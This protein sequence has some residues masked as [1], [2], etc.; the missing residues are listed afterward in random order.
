MNTKFFLF[1][2]PG[3]WAK[4]EL[5]F[6]HRNG[7]TPYSMKYKWD[8]K[9]CREFDHNSFENHISSRFSSTEFGG[10]MELKFLLSENIVRTRFH[11]LSIE[12]LK[13]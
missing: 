12:F 7:S 2:L 6:G 9:K 11:A 3:V 5:I 10:K 1:W 4:Y 8:Q 13:L